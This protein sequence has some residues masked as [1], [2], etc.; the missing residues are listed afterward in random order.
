MSTEPAQEPITEPI[1]A[2][3]QEP[4]T[5]PAP[6]SIEELTK[7]VAEL[8]KLDE[9]RKNEIAGLNRAN[10]EAATKYQDL[11]KSTETDKQT[12]DRLDKEKFTQD[13]AD[14]QSRLK[15]IS[16][17]K[18]EL[19]QLKIVKEAFKYGYTEEDLGFLK[20]NCPE[21]VEKHFKWTEA[22]DLKIKEG[23]VQRL[24]DSHS[25]KPEGYNNIKNNVDTSFLNGCKA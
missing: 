12:K 16:D 15:E 7:Q 9:T 1:G 23:T 4:T 18:T 20:F 13:E 3:P 21:D 8:S 11:L 10:T 5:E 2:E 19:N 6:L 25:G 14:K 22:R 17:T 24:L